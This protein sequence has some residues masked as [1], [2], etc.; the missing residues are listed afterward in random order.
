MFK[1]LRDNWWEV[2][3]WFESTWIGYKWTRLKYW[4]LYRFHPRHRYHV[5]K[6]T[7]RKGYSDPRHRM[8]H[9]VMR[10]ME[11]YVDEL[12][13]WDEIPKTASDVEVVL[14]YIRDTE[15]DIK[16]P[17]RLGKHTPVDWAHD[18]SLERLSYYSRLYHLL[19]WWNSVQDK[20]D[21]DSWAESDKEFV[22]GLR[23][24]LRWDVREDGIFDDLTI[25]EVNRRL[26]E[27][28]DL[29]AGMWT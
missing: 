5:L 21:L 25:E 29:R 2:L 19:V 20:D 10:C 4:F 1:R 7:D 14:R 22:I 3:F 24:E 11:E 8:I 18:Y 26:N 23:S 9:A 27:A 17:S 13:N 16:D 12:R 28:I 6:L 15:E